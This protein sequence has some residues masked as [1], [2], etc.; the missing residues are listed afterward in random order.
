MSREQKSSSDGRVRLDADTAAE[1][2]KVPAVRSQR[3]LGA[4]LAGAEAILTNSDFS[5]SARAIFDFCCEMTGATSGYVALLSEDGTEND[6][7]FL[8]AGD[9]SCSVDPNLPM[10]IRG[11]RAEAYRDRVPVYHNDFMNSEWA[12]MMPAG[13]VTL[14]NVMFAPLIVGGQAAGIIGLANKDGDF[15]DQD[16]IIAEGFGRLAAIALQN[17]RDVEARNRAEAELERLASIDAL[18]GLLNR[19][20]FLETAQREFDRSHRYRRPLSLIMIDLD[21]FKS[22]NDKYGHAF[23]DAVLQS[24]A[25]EL[26]KNVRSQDTAGRLGGEEFAILMPETDLHKARISAERLLSAVGKRGVEHDGQVIHFTVSCG[27]A[28]CGGE[29]SDIAQALKRADEALYEA[30]EAGRARV[31]SE[32]QRG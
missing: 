14:K 20:V 11:L 25:D 26:Q 6:L 7:L 29:D 23:G 10:P 15:N 22:I 17:S 24:F 8:E 30:K 5:A 12:K 19:R 18:T 4:F 2:A 3:A 1:L 9:L 32:S 16:A 21:H 31:C 28:Q 13:H 27:V